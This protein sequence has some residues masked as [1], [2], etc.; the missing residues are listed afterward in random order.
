MDKGYLKSVAALSHS[1][2]SPSRSALLLAA[3]LAACL[4]VRVWLVFHAETITKDGVG[5]IEMA[6]R[7]SDDPA[8]ALWN[9]RLQPGY[10]AAV[11]WARAVVVWCGGPSGITGWDLAGQMTSLVASVAAMLAV[12]FF[13]CALMDRR[14][15]LIAVL[16]FSLARK[17]SVAGSDVIAESLA[18][19]LQMWA[20]VTALWVR[21]LLQSGRVAAMALAAVTGVLSAGAY[22]VRTEAAHVAV[23]IAVCWLICGGLLDRK[24]APALAA[25]GVMLLAVAI[26]TVPF[27]FWIGA[28]TNDAVFAHFTPQRPGAAVPA[29]DSAPGFA[30]ATPATVVDEVEDDADEAPGPLSRLY[31]GLDRFVGQLFEAMHPVLGFAMCVWLIT[32]IGAKVLRSRLLAAMAGSPR[33][34]A[35]LLLVGSLVIMGLATIANYLH[36]GYMSHRYL[37]ANAA[38]LSPLGAAG[39]VVLVQWICVSGHKLRLPVFPRATI[40]AVVMPVAV[41]LLC[42]TLKPLHEGKAYVKQAGLCVA[43]Q[44]R[45][46]DFL[47]ADRALILH[48]A[49]VDG[50]HLAP[51]IRI[52]RLQM[53]I[54]RPDWPAT[55][56]AMSDRHLPDEQMALSEYLAE[57][58]GS[59]LLGRYFR[60]GRPDGDS[61]VVF[62]IGLDESQ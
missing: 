54:N 45:E 13:A 40:L 32:W 46:G 4:G 19:C 58:S 5:Y 1:Q 35:G 15:A 6:R 10:P 12:W 18:V 7:W 43:Q 30:D 62:R 9:V 57:Q 26:C 2:P 31:A 39:I 33:L 37:L 38:M 56:V 28:P 20:M 25:T 22:Y 44:A 53:W 47:I 14:I 23:V 61:I 8:D 3:A 48:Y 49:Q 55:V 41:G 59:V 29:H 60:D 36:A 11:S 24:L 42:H 21:R 51:P 27:M 34:P 16:L 50:R 17:W 52:D